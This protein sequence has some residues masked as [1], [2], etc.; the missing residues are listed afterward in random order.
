M[1][2][3]RCKQ[4]ELLQQFFTLVMSQFACYQTI[5]NKRVI[6]WTNML[7][8]YIVNNLLLPPKVAQKQLLRACNNSYYIIKLNYRIRQT[9]VKFE[10]EFIV[11]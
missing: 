1:H 6:I 10:E 11:I 8:W 5:D 7:I 2:Q 3:K 4:V 9:V